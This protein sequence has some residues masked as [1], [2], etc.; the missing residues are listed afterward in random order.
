MQINKEPYASRATS[1]SYGLNLTD[2][3]W[4]IDLNIGQRHRHRRYEG[5]DPFFGFRRDDRELTQSLSFQKS[6]FYVWGILPSIEVM[7]EKRK[8]NIDIVEFDRTQAVLSGT[9]LF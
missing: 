7:R 1:L 4:G 5:E 2:L 6:G 8:S 9:K 3:F